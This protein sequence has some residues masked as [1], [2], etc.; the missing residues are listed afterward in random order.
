MGALL[1]R[2]TVVPREESCDLFDED[3]DGEVDEDRAPERCNLVDDDCDRRVDEGNPEGGGTC[4][5]GRLGVCSAGTL[6]CGGGALRCVAN[7]PGRA[8]ACNGEDDDCD[9]RIDEHRREERCNGEDDDCDGRTDEDAVDGVVLLADCDRDGVAG[10]DA[11][12]TRWCR[13]RPQPTPA[14]TSGRFLESSFAE[15][16]Q[17]LDARAFPGQFESFARPLTVPTVGGLRWDFDCDGV[18]NRRY[19]SRAPTCGTLAS[20]RSAAGWEG[21]LPSCGE[22]GTWV[23]CVPNRDGTRCESDRATRA[24]P[25][26]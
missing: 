15:D 3:C 26:R 10:V 24:Q 4:S 18:E 5:T 1:C 20:C 25:C 22:L 7:L 9:G 6:R 17:D 23:Q 8:E 19:L 11:E 21:T 2:E 12:R 16:C 13:G 14:C